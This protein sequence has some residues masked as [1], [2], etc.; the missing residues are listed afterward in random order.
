MMQDAKCQMPGRILLLVTSYWFATLHIRW[1]FIKLK[2]DYDLLIRF[3]N[4]FAILMQE[5]KPFEIQESYSEIEVSNQQPVTSNL[6]GYLLLIHDSRL[7]I[8]F[9]PLFLIQFPIQMLH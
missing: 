3:T 1:S 9:R 2:R 7:S 4:L 6:R 8:L 5:A